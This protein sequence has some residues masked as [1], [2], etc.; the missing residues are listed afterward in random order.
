[1]I[2][3][4][5]STWLPTPTVA[6]I[7]VA[8]W[9]EAKQSS[10]P[11]VALPIPGEARW[12]PTVSIRSWLAKWGIEFKREHW[13]LSY[14]FGRR[15]WGQGYAAESTRT[16][17]NYFLTNSDADE[18]FAE[19]QEANSRSIRL[20]ERLARRGTGRTVRPK[21][22]PTTPIRVPITALSPNR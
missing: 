13:E 2:C 15:F 12:W 17:I 20:L 3:R 11:K 8:P 7:S 6:A 5:W 16:L 4:R 21:I 19:T 14:E 22:L 1:M 9:T 18:L 10:G